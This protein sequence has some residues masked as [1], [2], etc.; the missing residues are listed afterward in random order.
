LGSEISASVR[1]SASASNRY[2]RSDKG[3]WGAARHAP[4]P[5]ANDAEKTRNSNRR[6]SGAHQR[7]SVPKLCLLEKGGDVPDR[8][9][10]LRRVSDHSE[11]GEG[12]DHRDDAAQRSQSVC[13][14]QA[15][16]FAKAINR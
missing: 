14:D 2:P 6:G 8:R 16:R 13:A 7:S 4:D 12:E 11:S 9:C 10:S 3:Q 1:G 5:A 15:A